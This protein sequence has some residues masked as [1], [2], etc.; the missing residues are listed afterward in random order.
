MIQIG[1]RRSVTVE[2]SLQ[3]LTAT[4]TKFGLLCRARSDFVAGDTKK[5]SCSQKQCERYMVKE[6]RLF[7]RPGYVSGHKA[8]CPTY[9]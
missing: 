5:K 6:V 9:F 7:V 3:L 4:L 8:P 2:P 1:K